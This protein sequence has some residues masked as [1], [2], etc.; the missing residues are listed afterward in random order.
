[1]VPICVSNDL[2]KPNNCNR[3]TY[4]G[5][6]VMFEVY[7]VPPSGPRPAMEVQYFQLVIVKVPPGCCTVNFPP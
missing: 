3:V 1:M 4:F 2:L 5:G 7:G 6:F